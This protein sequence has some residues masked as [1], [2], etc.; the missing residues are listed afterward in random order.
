MSVPRA[1]RV[2]AAVLALV[3]A[4]ELAGAAYVHVKAFAAQH[5]LQLAWMRARD[6][7][8]APRPWP[9]ADTRPVARLSVPRLRVERIVLEGASGRSLAFGPG[10]LPGTAAPGS[11]GNSVLAAHRDTHF[12]FLR[13]LV[14][15]DVLV[16]ERTAGRVRRYRVKDP[17]VT[18]ADDAS[19]TGEAGDTRLTLVTCWPFDAVRPGTPWRYVVVAVAE[20]EASEGISH[21]GM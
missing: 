20:G 8:A 16:M 5:L 14:P 12:G 17:R 11:F 21:L 4:W 18:R 19:V 1:L 9:G 10:H 13:E 3:G 15:G 6:A 2:T 7:G